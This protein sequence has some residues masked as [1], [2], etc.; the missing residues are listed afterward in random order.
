MRC[1]V[2]CADARSFFN[3]INRTNCVPRGV[4]VLP[5]CVHFSR[6][7]SLLVSFFFLQTSSALAYSRKLFC[8]DASARS[9][10]LNKCCAWVWLIHVLRVLSVQFLWWRIHL[11]V[12]DNSGTRALA[13]C[14]H[15]H[16]SAVAITAVPIYGMQSPPSVNNFQ[17]RRCSTLNSVM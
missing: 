10:S 4:R 7:A 11:G 1:G 13:H 3:C 14:T 16:R 12:Y 5:S 15:S 2:F 6:V 8:S 9:V 17:N